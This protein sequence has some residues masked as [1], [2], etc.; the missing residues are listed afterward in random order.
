MQLVLKNHLMTYHQYSFQAELDRLWYYKVI[1]RED[2]AYLKEKHGIRVNASLVPVQEVT[3]KDLVEA[4]RRKCLHCQRVPRMVR[5]PKEM[6]FLANQP[7][8]I[9]HSDYVY[10]NN[11]GYLLTLMDNFSGKT[12]LKFAE[13]PTAKV[14]AT[15]LLEWRG[16]FSFEK[17]FLL[18]TDNGS[19]FANEI[20]KKL[21]E[22]VRF[23]QKFTVA[24]APWTNGIIERIN[25]PILKAVKAL[26]SEYGLT[27][28]EWP[29]LVPT[30]TH[31]IN[32]RKSA[33]RLN[34]SPNELFMGHGWDEEVMPEETREAYLMQIGDQQRMPRNWEKVRE[35]ITNLNKGL[36]EKRK[37]VYKFL[38]DK[39]LHQRQDRRLKTLQYQTGDYVM[40]SKANTKRERDKIKPVWYG[41]FQVIEIVSNNVYRVESLLGQEKVVH[42]SF[43]WFYEPKGYEPT[44]E[45][46]N[47]FLQ[48]Q[49]ELEIE[50]IRSWK[51]IRGEA[52]FEVK[53]LGF[54]DDQNTWETLQHLMEQ[55]PELVVGYAEKTKDKKLS[56]LVERA[57]AKKRN[58]H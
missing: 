23:S 37:R 47:I 13:S 24:Y 54:E 6:T 44:M 8:E 50:E 29:M 46:R 58:K 45:V 18:V 55:V 42:A 30:V 3:I 4:I 51:V 10:L 14:V 16:H 52:K 53:W 36:E 2:V 32:N 34:H 48:D 38:L 21:S 39:R 56:G 26:V 57:R 35:Y 49:G 20:L 9:L 11:H 12:Y 31:L 25:K 7:N 19:H 5:R 28:K 41:P 27:A 33:T 1:D 40:L 15:A 17:D 22:Y 43:M